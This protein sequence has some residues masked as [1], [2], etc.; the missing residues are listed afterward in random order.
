M[1]KDTYIPCLLQLFR[2][3]GYDG[4]TLARISEATGLGKASLYHHFPGGKDEMVQAVMDYLDAWLAEHVLPTL[5]GDDSALEKLQRMC[6]RL[7]ELYEAGRQPCI[8]ATLLLGSARD[9]FHDRVQ[10]RYSAWIRAV[11]QVLVDA[12]LDLTT[13]Q[14]RGEDMVITIQGSLI[15]AQG[16]DNPEIFQ[17]SLKQLPQQLCQNLG[18]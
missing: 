6:D 5:Q 2:H 15:V 9:L 13:A 14:Q 3:Y 10:A 16:L 1:P 8:T 12:G 4:A 11:A 18:T 7:S 17:R